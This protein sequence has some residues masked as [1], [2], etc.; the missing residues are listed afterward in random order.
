MEK[1]T[2]LGIGPKIGRIAL[3]YLAITLVLN[4]FFH[5]TFS[6][7]AS[8]R[9]PLLI[10]GLIL[11]AIALVFYIASVRLMFPGIRNNKLV[12]SGPY[13]LCRN[14]LY[15][16]LLLFLVPG[17]AMILNSWLILTTTLVGY[18]AFRRY[19]HEEEEMLRRIFGEEYREYHD[20]TPAL[21]PGIV[22][23]R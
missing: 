5:G 4:H 18:L 17:L 23:N 13:R 15:A 2:F 8:L 9:E 20:K 14:P 12:T 16:A 1:L 7:G 22:Q 10:A 11:L 6:F 19:I 3:P 21:F